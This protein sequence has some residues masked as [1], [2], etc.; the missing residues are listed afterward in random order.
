MPKNLSLVGLFF[1]SAVLS[2]CSSKP[3]DEDLRIATIKSLQAMGG[4]MAVNQWANDMKK[5]RVLSCSKE[6]DNAYN[7]DVQGLMGTE[8]VR[9]I[10]SED[11]WTLIEKNQ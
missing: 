9:M 5:L 3:T 11:G 4:K 8:R 6:G 7:C 10:K 1:M 2:A